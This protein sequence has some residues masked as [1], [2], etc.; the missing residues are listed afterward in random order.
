MDETF[1]DVYAEDFSQSNEFELH[2]FIYDIGDLNGITSMELL[3]KIMILNKKDRKKVL[4]NDLIKEK[5]RI[6]LLTESR[7]NQWYYYREIVSKINPSE[8]LSLYDAEFLNKYFTIHQGECLYRFWASLCENDINSIVDLIIDDDS[9]LD[10]F[11]K[12]S[13][14]FESLFQNLDYKLLLK[15]LYKLQDSG[16]SFDYD[17]LSSITKDNQYLLLEEQRIN[18]NTLIKILSYFYK[19][20]NSHFFQNN[21]RALYLYDKFDIPGLVGFGIKFNDNILK[22][23]DFFELLKDRSLIVF[24]NNVNNI[25]R[26]NNPIIIEGMVEQYYNDILSLYS[27]EYNMF[28][29]YKEILDNPSLFVN[30]DKKV[31]YLFHVDIIDEITKLLRKD[32]NGNYYFENKDDLELFLRSETSKKMSEVIIDGL[33]KD[34]IYNVWLNIKEM[35]RYNNGLNVNEK[36]LDKDKEKFYTMI[37]NFDK[38]SNVDKVDLF[39]SLKNKNVNLMFYQDLKM[40]KDYAYNKI[41]QELFDVSN[42]SMKFLNKDGVCVYDMRDMNYYMLVRTQEKY[43]EDSHY[44]R[45]CYSIISNQN[46]S[47]FGEC[48]YNSFLYGYNTFANDMVLHMFESDSFSSGF[49]EKSTRYVNRIMTIKEIVE[50]SYSYSEVQLVNKKIDGKK[51]KYAVM[52]PDFIVVFDNVRDKHIEEAKRLNIPIVIIKKQLLDDK[53]NIDFN[54]DIDS[55]VESIYNENEHRMRR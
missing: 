48:D 9:L 25:E 17:F 43:R 31:S 4:C 7:D 5:L 49:R 40:V 18:D 44:P 39:N 16:S 33:F 19:E 10:N 42:C 32:D 34:N 28:A 37:I 41:K 12:V 55:Y 20:V 1:M 36:I 21:K 6:G 23:K 50:A 14:N 8:F 15:L 30:W 53:I 3:D 24:R 2:K 47:V 27:H 29:P 22:R 45:N 26:N 38:L 52:K 13:N 11:L 35:L 54:E 46:T 51:Y